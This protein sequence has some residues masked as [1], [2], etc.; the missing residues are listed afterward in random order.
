MSNVHN[1]EVQCVRAALQ[2]LGPHVTQSESKC[3]A[4]GRV[5][6]QSEGEAADKQAISG[7]FAF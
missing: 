1:I 7:L 5:G 4:L 6:W 2:Q 3:Y